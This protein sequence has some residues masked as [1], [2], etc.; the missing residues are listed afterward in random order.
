M[1]AQVTIEADTID[2]IVAVFAF[3]SLLV[4]LF[5]LL[6]TDQSNK[7][8]KEA[9]QLA[10]EANVLSERT[11][12]LQEDQE[13]V[14]LAVKPKFMFIYEE[15]EPHIPRV[16]IEIVNLS[17]FPVT[18]T[19]IGFKSKDG[20]QFLIKNPTIGAPFNSLPARIP[21]REA[22]LAMGED[23]DATKT[24]YLDTAV[25]LVVT[26]CGEVIEGSMEQFRKDFKE[27]FNLGG[28]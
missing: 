15:Q 24:M 16:F 4:S 6:Q 3:C 18:V 12:R 11:M 10:T 2:Y 13:K 25:A 21:S 8:A 22:L 23:L 28:N 27:H 7:T 20:T 14:R 9:N 19:K 5:A 1:L 26:A 17:A